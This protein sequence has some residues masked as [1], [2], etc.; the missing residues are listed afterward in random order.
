MRR[1]TYLVAATVL[2]LAGCTG[3]GDPGESGNGSDGED[4]TPDGNDTDDD[5]GDDE[6][7]ETDDAGKPA[8]TREDGSDDGN[9]TDG[10]PGE[11]EFDGKPGEEDSDGESTDGHERTDDGP[12][13]E[14]SGEG[15]DSDKEGSGDEGSDEGGDA[16]PGE[17]IEPD[18]FDDF[19]DLSRW[20]VLEGSLEPTDRSYAGEQAARL[21]AG[22]LEEQVTIGYEFDGPRDLR[23]VVP[24]IAVA[25]GEMVVPTIRLIDAD[26][27]RVDYRRAIKGGVPFM[28]YNFGVSNVAGEPDLG[29]VTELQIGLWT[30]L[31]DG[32]SFRCDDLHFTPR[33]ATGKVMIQFDDTHDTDYT[34]GL[35]ILEEYG[36]PATT[37][38]N[39]DRVG[40]EGWLSLDQLKELSAAGW[41]VGSHTLSHPNLTELDRAAQEEEI[42]GAREWLAE[43]GFGGEYFAYPFG[44]YDGDTLK[45]VE[46]NHELG[47]AGGYPVQGRAVNPTLCTRIGDAEAGRAV[48]M[49]DRTAEMRG[50]TCLFYHRLEGEDLQNFEAAIDHLAGLESAGELDVITPRDL[51]EGLRFPD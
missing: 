51:S 30:G 25:A 47:F 7:A 34:E 16:E 40:G 38:V 12:E 41:T 2:T 5:G 45:I 10:E 22:P 37:F 20:E 43:H 27:D 36:Y 17:P 1:R 42:A 31:F 50:V 24:G 13:E 6:P 39:P 49:L 44:E 32:R 18:T 4:S 46:E 28:R 33:P 11:E 15:N 26:G 9:G 19:S 8:D 23:D 48:E 3:S 29:R 14:T 35:A 21:K